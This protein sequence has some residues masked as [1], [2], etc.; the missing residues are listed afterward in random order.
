MYHVNARVPVD[1]SRSSDALK[2]APA[3]KIHKILTITS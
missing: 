3:V 1:Q 2:Y